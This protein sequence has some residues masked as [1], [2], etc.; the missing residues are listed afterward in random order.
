MMK[1]EEIEK[2]IQSIA[3]FPDEKF[4]EIIREVGF[5]CDCC[6]KCCTSEFND[7]VFLLDDDTER[8]IKN[9]GSGNLRPAPYFDLCD[10][11]GRFYVMGYALK[12]KPGGDCIFYTG[13]RCEH[14]AIRP[15]ICR[16]FPYML[17]REPDEKGNIEF[18]QV[19][20]LNRHGLYHSD[21]SDDTCKE[22][23][24]TV[25][26]YESDFLRQKLGFIREIEKH[27][28]KNNLKQS[29]QMYDRMMREYEKGKDIEVYVF[30]RGAFKKEIISKHIINP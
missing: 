19:G 30:F 2:E 22:I 14:Y 20:G 16:I 10:N 29:R 24:K 3:S 9:R 28:K 11:L 8:L 13:G 5:E 21:I 26:K 4:I 1:T 7:H 12:N 25:K 27:F 6:G 23:L 17:H 15:D 18:R